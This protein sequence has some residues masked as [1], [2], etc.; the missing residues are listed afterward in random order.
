MSQHQLNLAGA[1]ASGQEGE[2]RLA[3]YEV[4]E[5]ARCGEWY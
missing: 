1:G 5:R 3:I 4:D 2:G